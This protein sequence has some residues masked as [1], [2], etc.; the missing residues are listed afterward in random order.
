[1]SSN[2]NHRNARRLI[3]IAI[4]AMALLA[5]RMTNDLTMI[6][7][8]DLRKGESITHK[9][10]INSSITPENQT[11]L[12]HIVENVTDYARQQNTKTKYLLYFSQSGFANQMIC[13]K[14]A[15]M[16]ALTL[17]RVLLLP[18]ILP[19]HLG[20]GG[21]SPFFVM[22]RQKREFPTAESL[23][24]M[25]SSDKKRLDPFH[26][27]LG[28]LDPSLYLSLGNVLD[29]N[30]TLPGIETMDVREF[31]N[32]VYKHH[33]SDMTKATIEIDYGYSNMNTIWIQNHTTLEGETMTNVKRNMYSKPHILNMTYRDII[34]T[35]AGTRSPSSPSI[36]SSSSEG[37]SRREVE[38]PDIL[39]FLDTFKTQ[40]H[41]SLYNTIPKCV[42]TM[43][44]FIRQTVRDA[45]LVSDENVHIDTVR[46][47][48]SSWPRFYAAVHI[49]GGD[50]IFALAID[51]TIRHVFKGITDVIV[52]WLKENSQSLPTAESMPTI[53]LYVATDIKNIRKQSIFKIETLRLQTLL[54]KEHGVDLMILFQKHSLPTGPPKKKNKKKKKKNSETDPTATSMLGGLLYADLFWDIQVC[55][56]APIGFQGSSPRS[57]LSKLMQVHRSSRC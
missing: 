9:K 7:R 1:M 2:R 12:A 51:E 35:L 39:V 53:G 3:G 50:S 29:L 5:T 54:R 20:Q 10:V 33:T 15:Y 17:N 16:M 55:A 47:G 11:S 23:Q 37:L 52:Q 48:S 45:V 43:T 19:H 24:H 8:F 4:C 42:P 14:H 31:Y 46:P 49:R 34:K 30:L 44:P 22:D 26:V 25:D 13:L 36:L 28:R 40:F 41:K 6:I 21:A 38:D 56:C 57:S 18:P 27:Y 32:K